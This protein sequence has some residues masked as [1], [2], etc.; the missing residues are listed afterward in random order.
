MLVVSIRIDEVRVLLD[1]TVIAVESSQYGPL[2]IV[3]YVFVLVPQGDRYL[4]DRVVDTRV[5]PIGTPP[6]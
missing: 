4:V 2:G 1:G 6:A 3:T 5:E